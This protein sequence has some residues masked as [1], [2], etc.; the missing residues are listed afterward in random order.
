[1][2]QERVGLTDSNHDGI[3]IMYGVL[4]FQANFSGSSGINPS[5][6]HSVEIDQ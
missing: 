1:M 4:G 3:R 2:F 6:N 5:E